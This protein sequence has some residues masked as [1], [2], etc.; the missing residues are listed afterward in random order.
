MTDRPQLVLA[1]ANPNKVAELTD[2]L[3]DGFEISPRPDD[4]ADTVEDGATLEE[5]AIKKATEVSDHSAAVALADDTGLFVEAL[6]GRPGVESARFA[7]PQADDGAN[8]AR[9]L[10]ELAGEDNRCA[11]FE[12]VI[13]VV[14]VEPGRP[15]IGRGRVHGWIVEH[16]RGEHG[17]G[18]D[19]LFQPDLGDGRT[20]AEMTLAEKQALSHRRLALSDLVGQLLG[21]PEPGP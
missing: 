18:Y 8:R 20:F 9:L 1:T 17:F 16:A 6:A 5:N 10:T 11:Y 4:L 12:T 21:P 15:I 3:G 19:S 7:G 2:L 13:A 14:G